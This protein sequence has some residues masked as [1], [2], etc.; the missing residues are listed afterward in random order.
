MIHGGFDKDDAARIAKSVR[1]TESITRDIRKLQQIRI[2][3]RQDYVAV[4]HVV[5][6]A[7][8][9]SDSSAA[10]TLLYQDETTGSWSVGD[11]TLDAVTVY[12]KSYSS[13]TPITSG[14]KIASGNV[15]ICARNPASG[16]LNVIGAWKCEA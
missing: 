6:T 2:P 3:K 5:L 13:K 1:Y 14:K 12:A 8:L 16:L 4:V 11:A 15:V 10:G 9:N 7:D